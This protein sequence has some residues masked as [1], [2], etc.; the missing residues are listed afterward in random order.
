MLASS[1][2]DGTVL[3]WDISNLAEPRPVTRLT[4]RRLVNAA[5]WNPVHAGLLATASA[6]KTAAVWETGRPEARLLAV[7]AR[8][9]D[10]VNSLAWLPDG[11]RLVCVSE[12]GSATIWDALNGRFLSRLI[13]HA[14]HC[15]MAACGNDGLVATVGE[16]GMVAV[17]D[18]YAGTTSTR[19]YP[20]SVEG[21]AWSRSSG[22]LAVG[23]DDGIVDVLDRELTVL[24]SIR[25]SSSAARSVAWS[26]DSGRLVVGSYDGMVHVLSGEGEHLGQLSDDRMWPRSVA[27][28]G[29]VIAV[30]S[31][32]SAPFLL[33]L[34]SCEIRFRP[35]VPTHGPNAL[36]ARGSHELYI[37]TD[38]GRVLRVD[39]RP[40]GRLRGRPATRT[41]VVTEGPVLSLSA[42]GGQ[43]AV[44]TYSGR[45][46]SLV[47]GG[48]TRLGDSVGTPLPSVLCQRH[49]IIGGT[50][51]G[52]LVV[53]DARSLATVRRERAHDGS[54]KAL[55]GL[56]ADIFVS[57]ATD[58]LV[59]I[60]SLTGR[61][62]LWEHGNLVN[63]VAVLGGPNRAVI[64]SASRD[65]T[66]K[67]GWVTRQPGAR[68]RVCRLET[69]IGPDESVKCVS[70]LGTADAPT[71]LA[72]SY[73]F[74]LYAWA[75]GPLPEPG[76]LRGGTL[77]ASYGQGLS[78]MCRIDRRTAAVAGWD[79]R[80][81]V[82]ELV[83]SPRRTVR[84]VASFW[85]RDLIAS[86]AAGELA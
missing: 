17:I 84:E 50:Y 1:S 62:T 70:L 47:M 53:V 76:G 54:V 10:D 83:P 29:G 2:Y 80:V 44:G 8:H 59:A 9:T 5:A 23:R 20:V 68:W 18:P 51:G 14:A 24:R 42:C 33:D 77:V 57:A 79:G 45:I 46:A 81:G 85:V 66:V 71:V 86:A 63:S 72:G 61:Q 69:L 19:H 73:D 26:D 35:A 7:L 6:D 36:T 67:V 65:H 21:C 40:P 12:D 56:D 43:V 16:D 64:A 75:L 22:L 25:V 55:A 4:H 15:M 74:G 49:V 58:R 52:D 34:D 48:A 11:R 38:S 28:A 32:W 13:S 30:G 3:T 37:G 39:P 41:R 78:C 27:V 82:Y 60:G 31:F